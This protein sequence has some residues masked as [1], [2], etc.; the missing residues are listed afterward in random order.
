VLAFYTRIAPWLL[1]ELKDRPAT[2]ERLPDGLGGPRF[3]QKNL[4][5][6]TP[7]WIPRIQLPTENGKP[8]NYALVNNE[9]TLLYLVNQGA[10][11]FHTWLSRV[12][13]L[14]R[15]DFVL[16]DLDPTEAPFGAAVKCA[17]SIHAALNAE[18]VEGRVKTS[19]KTGLHITVPWQKPGG[20]DESRAWALRIAER[21][22]HENPDL[23]TTERSRSKR[24]GRVYIDVMQ[25]AKGHHA[26]PAYVLRAVPEATVSTPLEWAELTPRLNPGKFT[27][28]TIFRRLKR[29]P[30]DG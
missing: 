2:L 22:V 15:P 7:S 23:A 10:L 28:K 21:V 16:F 30:A 14:D 1:P 18:G 25:N 3:W 13:D 12:Q 4:P 27:I 8:V 20:Y 11:T 24:A 29:P 19:G 9:Q 6:S 17:Q 26:V 5:T